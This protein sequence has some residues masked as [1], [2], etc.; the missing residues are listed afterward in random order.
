MEKMMSKLHTNEKKTKKMMGMWIEGGMMRKWKKRLNIIYN[1]KDGK[2]S[3]EIQFL[4]ND[5]LF[6]L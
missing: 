6:I 2:Q 1:Q 5:L 3:V 4:F